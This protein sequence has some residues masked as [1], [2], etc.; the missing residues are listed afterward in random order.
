MKAKNLLEVIIVGNKNLINPQLGLKVS[1]LENF[2][3][4][5]SINGLFK[6]SFFSILMVNSGSLCTKMNDEK[7]HLFVN[8]IIIVPLKASFEI[9]HK[10]NPL[11]ICML[12]FSEEFAYENSISRSHMGYFEFFIAKYPFKI[13]LKNKDTL[14]LISLFELLH[15]KAVRTNKQVFKE[16][17]LLHSFSLL[18]YEVTEKYNKYYKLNIKD[19][20]KEKMMIQFFKILETNYKEQ[21]G[22]KFYAAE[23][24]IT[25][26]HLTKIVKDGTRKTAKQ[27]IVDAIILEAKHL[28]QKE[29]LN[30]INIAE[31]LQFG[32][33]SLFSNFFKKHT[34]LSPSE[35]RLSLNIENTMK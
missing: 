26:D 6:D 19:S 23:L 30:I 13:S 15:R 34:S 29:D 27:F 22:V 18:L 32:N 35:Y 31:E 3:S 14:H 28:L 21:H 33:S 8:D 25:A 9:Q 10:T 12:S 4:K 20:L 5:I 16:E 7:I 1:V 24:C 2:T 17:V 11:Q